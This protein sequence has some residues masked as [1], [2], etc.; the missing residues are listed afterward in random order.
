MTGGEVVILGDVGKNFAAGMSGGVAYVLSKDAEQFKALC[1]KEMIIFEKLEE[2]AEIE[3]IKG[4][5]EKHMELTDSLAAQQVLANWDKYV[6]QFVKVIPKD[7]K[8]MIANIQK[9][10]EGG[11]SEEAAAMEAFEN[12][13][14]QDKKKQTNKITVL[15]Q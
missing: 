8:R 14:K 1:N 4:L 2:R 5:L 15:V 3:R 10:L 9:G 12:N 7:Y 13:S 11:L 6:Q